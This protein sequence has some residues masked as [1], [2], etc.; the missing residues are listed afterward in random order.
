MTYKSD[1]SFLWNYGHIK[2]I[3]GGHHKLWLP[4]NETDFK[5]HLPSRPKSFF[6]LAKR[7]KLVAWIVSQCNSRS[8]REK[9]VELLQKE[10]PGEVC[11]SRDLQLRGL[12]SMQLCGAS[13]CPIYYIVS[14]RG[15]ITNN[16]RTQDTLWRDVLLGR[17][18]Y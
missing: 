15:H 16:S 4:Y 3:G 6:A 9:Y 12:F 5:L 11:R 10:I 2:E 17:S 14:D 8:R 1:S 7:P 13:M 18:M